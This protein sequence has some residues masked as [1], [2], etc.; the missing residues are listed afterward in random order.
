MPSI[1]IELGF[2]D[3]SEDNE[4]LEKNQDAYAEAIAQA[5]LDTFAQYHSKGAQKQS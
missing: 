5:V 4:L 3:N 2:M 1:L